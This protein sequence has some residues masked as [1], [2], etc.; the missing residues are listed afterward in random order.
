MVPISM[1]VVTPPRSS[2]AMEK[3]TQARPPSSSCESLRTGSISKRPENQNCGL[4]QSSMKERS[5]GEPLMCACV[6]M[7]PGVSTR[8]VASTASSTR[9]A[10][11]GP[12]WRMLSPSITTTPSRRSRCPFPSKA[13]TYT[14]RIATRFAAVINPSPQRRGIDA[15]SAGFA[16]ATRFL[17]EARRGPSRPLRSHYPD[18]H[19]LVDAVNGVVLEPVRARPAAEDPANVLDGHHHRLTDQPLLDALERLDPL[20]LLQRGLGLLEQRVGAV[21]LPAHGVGARHR[22]GHEEV[23]EVGRGVDHGQEARVVLPRPRRR[24]ESR[25]LEPLDLQIEAHLAELRLHGRDDALVQLRE[26]IE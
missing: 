25:R 24:V 10:Q 17:G 2:S 19:E 20:G 6:E 22:G 23:E 13:M 8:S 11:R 5:S 15:P 18:V 3:S 26:H 9:P 16:G 7:R 14:A 4:P 12:T 21:V 1:T